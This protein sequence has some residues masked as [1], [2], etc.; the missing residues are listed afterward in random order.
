MCVRADC[1][2]S[3]DQIL[4]EEVQKSVEE[5]IELVK[6]AGSDIYETMRQMK[7]VR[8]R[9]GRAGGSRTWVGGVEG[10]SG[11]KVDVTLRQA[12][13]NTRLYSSSSRPLWRS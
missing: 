13:A 10:V 11:E 5:Q 3:A 12:Y 1:V 6:S 8:R 2:L 7:E 4:R 9:H